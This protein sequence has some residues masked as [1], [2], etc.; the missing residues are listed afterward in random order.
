MM[1]DDQPRQMPDVNTLIAA[2]WP[3]HI[4]HGQ[5][6]RWLET[7]TLSGWATC[8]VVQSGFLRISMNPAVVGQAATFATALTLLERYTSDTAHTLWESEAP[9]S[10]WPEWLKQRVQGYRQVTDA[11]LLATAWHH[12]GVLVTLDSGLLTLLPQAH[13]SRVRVLVPEVG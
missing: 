12:G 7:E 2:A 4:H 6:R 11:T 3:N 9:P 1:S 13:R 10:V 8:P 5:A